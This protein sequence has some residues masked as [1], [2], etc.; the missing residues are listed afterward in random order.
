MS[1]DY[2]RNNVEKFQPSSYKILF[3]PV[4]LP[5]S[6]V[7]AKGHLKLDISDTSEDVYLNSLIS[8]V[9]NFAEK[10]TK[11][12]FIT[13]KYLTYI[14]CFFE[15]ITLR[16]NRVSEIVSIQYL[17]ETVLTAVDSSIY[18]LTDEQN[19]FADILLYDGACFPSD[20]DNRK[21]A[22]QIQFYSGFGV[23]IESADLVTNVVT[24]TT[25]DNHYFTTG[26]SIVISGANESIFN[27]TFI[28]TVTG[29]KTFTY[30]VTNANITATGTLFANDIPQDLKTA[31][32]QH[33]SRVY[34]NR[35]DCDAGNKA[36][37][38]ISSSINL[39][40]ETK[41]TYAMY[42]IWEVL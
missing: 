32:L 13:K 1:Y 5:I 12:D 17:K 39:P 35:G 21:Q 24:V 38:D 7:E 29:D 26:Q 6:L 10:Y 27:G 28:I 34:E 36:A 40:A 18:Y 37:C 16:R 4:T 2:Y 25:V 15:P 30:A 8:S 14:D 20:L 31:M 11:R 42:R 23:K 41:Q 9:T 22:I 19:D 33:V 3:R